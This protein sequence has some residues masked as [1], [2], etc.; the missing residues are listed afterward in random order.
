MAEAQEARVFR[1]PTR[2]EHLFAPGPKRLLSI[3][4][5][6][7]KGLISLAFLDRME[8]VLRDRAGAVRAF[9]LCDY[10]DLVGGT[11]S[12]ALIA[13]A[14]AAGHSVSEIKTVYLALCDDALGRPKFL[15][16]QGQTAFRRAAWDTACKGL[17]GEATL[18]SDRLRTGLAIFAARADGGRVETLTNH[19]TVMENRPKSWAGWG[20]DGAM[21]LRD[22]VRASMPVTGSARSY[23]V[24]R[25]APNR[26]GV[27]QDGQR[28]AH[29]NAAMALYTLATAR[30]HG[31]GW[32]GGADR[33]SVV[34]VGTGRA[35]GSRATQHAD[36]ERI[37]DGRFAVDSL[38]GDVGQFVE[39]MMQSAGLCLTRPWPVEGA[40][41]A[42]RM[43]P[44]G[45]TEK[46]FSYA[47]YNV[48]WEKRWLEDVVGRSVSYRAV[49]RFRRME[50]LE[51]L[52]PALALAREIAETQVSPDH[53]QPKFNPAYR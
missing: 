5:G 19:P 42:S 52:R 34:S 53:F 48:L 35:S 8:A 23:D 2:I 33:L 47:R 9:R 37:G 1:A 4:G 11:G 51:A 6:A 44:L 22:A 13:S 10:F 43:A 21:L 46:P 39:A 16:P 36:A 28:S 49:D 27:F 38:S 20:P 24:I 50:T 3:D 15:R 41:G 29:A 40:L 45:A 31:F 7:A 18:Q 17:F 30:D 14:L 26:H 32:T 12:G 25:L